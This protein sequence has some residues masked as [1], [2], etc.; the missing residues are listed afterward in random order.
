MYPIQTPIIYD[1]PFNLFMYLFIIPSQSVFGKS[2]AKP[3]AKAFR[4]TYNNKLA[5]L[6]NKF[7]K[8]TFMFFYCQKQFCE[9]FLCCFDILW[10]CRAPSRGI[11]MRGQPS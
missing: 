5:V 6:S 7:S 4:K 10:L 2:F 1:Y 3:L 11:G 9:Q 8:Q